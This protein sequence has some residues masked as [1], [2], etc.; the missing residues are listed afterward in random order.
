MNQPFPTI[1]VTGGAGFIGS[2]LC[3]KLVE[4]K[5]RIICLD[6]FEPDYPAPVKHQNI[7]PLLAHENFTLVHGDV[8][9][10]E[11]LDDVFGRFAVHLV[12]HLAAK[13][14]VRSS[15]ANPER[16]FEVNV[17]GTLRLLEAMRKH[18]VKKILFSSSS[19]VYGSGGGSLAEHSRTD[20]Q[21]SP[22]AVSKKSGELLLHHYHHTFGFSV[23]ALRLFSVYGE[24]Q[25]PDLVIHKYV[26]AIYHGGSVEVFGDG[27]ATRDFTHIDDVLQGFIAAISHLETTEGVK[28]EVF[29]IGAGNP[30]S[31]NA[32]IQELKHIFSEKPIE[33]IHKPMV[34]GDMQSTHADLTKSAAQLGYHPNVSFTSGLTSFSKWFMLNCFNKNSG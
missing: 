10:A 6:N 9:D 17:I 32:L 21:L 33:V 16:C 2:S 15:F 12:I 31:I 13:P 8:L 19:S 20:L 28:N 14:G 34:R 4:F 26:E 18:D 30:I 1:L 3:A 24:R 11:K 22:Y 25:R 5:W 7:A 29:N 27:E 23:V